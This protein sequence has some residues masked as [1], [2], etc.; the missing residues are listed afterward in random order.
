MVWLLVGQAAATCWHRTY[1]RQKVTSC[2]PLIAISRHLCLC[3]SFSNILKLL[4]KL[5]KTRF[6]MDVNFPLPSQSTKVAQVLV[7]INYGGDNCQSQLRCEARDQGTP[8][9]P[10]GEHSHSAGGLIVTMATRAG[11]EGCRRL[12][13]VL[14]SRRRPLLLV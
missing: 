8:P 10:A 14:Q 7:L 6:K 4:K 9:S 5:R 11:N 3:Y 12:R 2:L 13:K 1:N